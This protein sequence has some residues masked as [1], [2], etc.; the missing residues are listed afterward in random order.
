[1]DKYTRDEDRRFTLRIDKE[2]FERI[3]A[4]AK[5]CKRS[6]GRHIEYLLD[7]H[8]LANERLMNGLKD[9]PKTLY[10]KTPLKSQDN[11]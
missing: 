6:V 4:D 9:F 7:Q 1:M 2:L 8:Y 3:E 5:Q 11:D 10:L